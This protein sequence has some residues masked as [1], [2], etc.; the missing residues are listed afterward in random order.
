MT[1]LVYGLGESGVA[2]ARALLARGE[3]VVAADAADGERLRR[4][5]GELG[6]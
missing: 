5:L 3:R 2:A 6:V 1:V 4:T